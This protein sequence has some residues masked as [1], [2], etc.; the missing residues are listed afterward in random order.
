MRAV[1]M[2]ETPRAASR[3][4]LTLALSLW[5]WAADSTEAAGEGKSAEPN[6]EVRVVTD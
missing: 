6:L 1:V 2:T 5:A 3:L 4:W